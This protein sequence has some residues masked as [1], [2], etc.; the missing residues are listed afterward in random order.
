MA[1]EAPKE[2]R[3]PPPE[4]FTS[5]QRA[6]IQKW[7][8]DHWTSKTCPMC[9]VGQFSAVRFIVH[10]ESFDATTHEDTGS[11]GYFFIPIAC[12]NCSYTVFI[13]AVKLGLWRRYKPD[14][15]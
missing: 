6:I 13:N 8:D 9:G 3:K 10:P 4:G 7:L 15:E 1:E 11:I 2:K 14:G 12:D 5:E